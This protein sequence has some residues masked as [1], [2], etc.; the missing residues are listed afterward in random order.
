MELKPSL[1]EKR[2]HASNTPNQNVPR[3]ESDERSELEKT[4]QEERKSYVD[5]KNSKMASE[6]KYQ[7]FTP[8]NTELN[9]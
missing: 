3:E 7:G 8:V 6:F 4:E 5:E 1:N 2:A 9:A